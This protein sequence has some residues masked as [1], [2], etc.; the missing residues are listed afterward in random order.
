VKASASIGGKGDVPVNELF[1]DPLLGWG[2]YVDGTIEVIEALGGHS[3][4]LQEPYVASLARTLEPYL[5]G[6]RAAASAAPISSTV[7]QNP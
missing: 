3:S 2:K 5:P 6:G 1:S 7:P 4:M